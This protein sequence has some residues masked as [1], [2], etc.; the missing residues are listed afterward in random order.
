MQSDLCL[1][2]QVLLGYLKGPKPD[3][4]YE[5]GLYFCAVALAISCTIQ[6]SAINNGLKA[7]GALVTSRNCPAAF[8]FRSAQLLRRG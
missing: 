5:F 6:L 8:M 2:G 7:E 1:P 4:F 3:I